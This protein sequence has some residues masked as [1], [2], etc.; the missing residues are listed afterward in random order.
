LQ[1][2]EEAAYRLFTEA[3]LR[4]LNRWTDAD[5]NYSLWLLERPSFNFRPLR[6]PASALSNTPFGV[7]TLEEFQEMRAAWD[8]IT[9]KMIPDSM[10]FESPIDLRH[11]CLFYTGHIPTFLDIHLSRLLGEPNTEPEHFKVRQA[12]IFSL[13][14]CLRILQ[15]IFERGIDPNVDDPTECHVGCL[16]M[17]DLGFS[18]TTTAALGSP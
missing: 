3:N 11:I 6:S 1:Y 14:T 5:S 12:P 10:M 9:T 13:V 18:C 16:V 15:Y 7:P 17:P 4:P 8:F 2:T